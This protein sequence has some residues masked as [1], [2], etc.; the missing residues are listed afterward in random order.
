ML[1]CAPIAGLSAQPDTAHV[2]TSAQRYLGAWQIQLAAIVAE[3]R[4]EQARS[5][6]GRPPSGVAS[7]PV[8]AGWQ[9]AET[10]QTVAD[11]LFLRVPKRDGWMCFRDVFEVDGRPVRDRQQRFDALFRAPGSDIA[12]SAL[13]IANESARF[14]LG[15][16][17]RNVNTPATALIF[18]LPA[19]AETIDW[20]LDAR[21][22]YD[23]APAWVLG[24]RQRRPPF[25][26]RTPDGKRVEASGRFWLRPGDAHIKATEVVLRTKTI[27][28][29][30]HTAYG[31]ARGLEQW[32]PVR[33]DD[34]YT[35]PGR[36]RVTGSAAYGN[37]RVFQTSARV[38]GGAVK[39]F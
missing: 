25:A 14:N 35:I 16:V 20:T 28:S 18:L 7:H 27:S 3:E 33:M 30:V 26:V 19:F 9:P 5:V 10:R 13:A 2:V 11:V 24:F 1:A 15:A 12:T 22:A 37:H 29:R 31:P 39:Q 17:S 23:G 38:V 21:G 6:F 34:E 4:Y 36:E 32:V 8:G